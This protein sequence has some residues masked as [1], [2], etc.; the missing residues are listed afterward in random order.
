MVSTYHNTVRYLLCG[1]FPASAIEVGLGGRL[2]PGF[3][4]NS[5]ILAPLSYPYHPAKQMVH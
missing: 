4:K 1:C 2:N 5:T 3:R